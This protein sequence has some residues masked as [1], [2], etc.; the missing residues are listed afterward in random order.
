LGLLTCKNRL[1]YNLYCVG[2]D[3]KHSTI[4]ISIARVSGNKNVKFFLSHIFVKIGSI[5]IKSRPKG[6]TAHYT[7]IIECVSSVE[8]LHFVIFVCHVPHLH[9]VD[10][11]LESGGKFIFV[12]EV[13]PYASEWWWRRS[14]VKRSRSLG[15]TCI[16]GHESTTADYMS[17]CRFMSTCQMKWTGTKM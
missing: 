2:G 17:H 10:S 15:T 13:T 1:P 6:S 9:F 4:S 5:Y 11:V 8:M 14:K 3:V 12:R 7:C 16:I